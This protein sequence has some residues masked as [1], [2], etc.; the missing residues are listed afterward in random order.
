MNQI[1]KNF[2]MN[3]KSEIG[4]QNLSVYDLAEQIK[5]APSTIYNMMALK[6]GASIEMADRLSQALKVPLVEMLKPQVKRSEINVKNAKRLADLYGG[7]ERRLYD[8]FYDFF[9]DDQI[10]MEDSEIIQTL[11]WFLGQVGKEESNVKSD[12]I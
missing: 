5:V 6:R 4:K 7:G 3:L 2:C 8:V 1:Q 11:N 10:D 9:G 12:K